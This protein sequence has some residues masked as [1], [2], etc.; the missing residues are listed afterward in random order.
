MNGYGQRIKTVLVGGLTA[1]GFAG[2]FPSP[3]L[4]CSCASQDSAQQV[5]Q[6][7]VI[8]S[9][10]PI[11]RQPSDA[12]SPSHKAEMA[13]WTFA[14]DG[15]MKGQAAPQQQVSSLSQESACGF[16]FQL[17]Q[18]YL[19]YSKRVGNTL[20]TDFCSGTKAL[21]QGIQ[22]VPKQ[23]QGKT[24]PF[25]VLAQGSRVSTPSRK[26]LHVPG[27]QIIGRRSDFFL[28][29]KASPTPQAQPSVEQPEVKKLMRQILAVDFDNHLV[30]AVYQGVAPSPGHRIR[31]RKVQAQAGQIQ[32]VVELVKPSGPQPGVVAYPYEVIVLPRHQLSLAPGTTWHLVDTQGRQLAQTIYPLP[33]KLPEVERPTFNQSLGTPPCRDLSK[34]QGPVIEFGAS[35]SSRYSRTT[36]DALGR[37]TI[38]PTHYNHDHPNIG[39]KTTRISPL[40]VQ[41]LVQLAA[42]EGF[43]TMPSD[44]AT[45]AR[46]EGGGLSSVLTVQPRKFV[47]I[48]LSCANRT[49]AVNVS[50]KGKR[51]SLAPI[52]YR[53]QNQASQEQ[54]QRFNELYELLSDLSDFS[55]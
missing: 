47:T 45:P 43:W 41:A 16:Q 54:V 35:D 18:R 44:P 10:T 34:Q 8:F 20:V 52:T 13:L 31:V 25:R 27:L 42:A 55:P 4:A 2:L 48:L 39:P 38:H 7:A 11:R 1:S 6:A 30:V 29:S 28:G 12:A 23:P 33:T 51:L 37:V 36:I 53:F 5:S 3:A 17:N 15:V 26:A 40:S 32:V 9:G 22:S 19:V 24:I 50:P 21:A 14:V 49:V 46:H